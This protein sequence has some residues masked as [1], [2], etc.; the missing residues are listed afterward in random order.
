MRP[1][2][3]RRRRLGRRERRDTASTAP[4][5]GPPT[6]APFD[7][8][9]AGSTSSQY[10]ST[11]AA[12]N[13]E[14]DEA[15]DV[16]VDVDRADH[17]RAHQRRGAGRGL[18][19]AR[20]AWPSRATTGDGSGAVE[21]EYRRQRRRVDGLRERVRR[22]GQPA[23]TRSTSAR[24]TSPATS[25]TSRRC[26]S[27]S[28]RRRLRR[29]RAGCRRRRPRRRRS[30]SRRSRTA[31]AGCD[32]SRAARRQVHGAREL[33][34]RRRAARCTL[35]VA[36]ARWPAA[37]A[38]D[39]PRSPASALRCGDEG[40]ATVTLKPS[41][42]AQALARTEELDQRDV[43]AAHDGRGRGHA[44]RDVQGEVVMS[45]GEDHE[46]GTLLRAAA[47]ERAAGC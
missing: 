45:E 16:R 29:R 6:A 36:S 11:D 39:A 27:R 47:R 13:V 40:R 28:G 33:P 14:A 18:H 41:R 34:G 38:Q 5:R 2:R 7:V 21:T 9:G 44:D 42:V 15:L 8:G 32:A 17:D 22:L 43:D 24:P 30:R 12:G 35:T 26:C 20:S 37:Q 23:A 46:R 3:R 1:E 10:R 31:L 19:R 4:R 25:R